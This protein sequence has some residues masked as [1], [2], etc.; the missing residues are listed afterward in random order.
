MIAL[1][2]AA[3]IRCPE[4]YEA[5]GGRCEPT[6]TVPIG[7]PQ[8]LTSSE[9][10]R[11]YERKLCDELE[12]CFCDVYDLETCDDIDVRCIDVEEPTGCAFDAEVAWD[13]LHDHYRCESGVGGQPTVVAPESCSRVYDCTAPTSTGDTG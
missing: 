11:D 5:H 6:G 12:E 2:L 1:L 9:F 13:C 7:T 4:G 8:P 3:C 10:V